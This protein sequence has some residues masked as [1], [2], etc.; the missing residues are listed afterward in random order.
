MSGAMLD[1]RKDKLTSREL[2]SSR[3]DVPQT[4]WP[5]IAHKERAARAL[6]KTGYSTIMRRY[7][8]RRGPQPFVQARPITRHYAALA[9]LN[10]GPSCSVQTRPRVGCHAAQGRT[11]KRGSSVGSV[12][13]QKRT[14]AAT[15]SKVVF[16]GG[17]R[18]PPKNCGGA[19][20][21]HKCWPTGGV[22]LGEVLNRKSARP[23][24]TQ[25]SAEKV[26]TPQR[27]R[28]ALRPP[29][30][31]RTVQRGGLT[32]SAALSPSARRPLKASSRVPGARSHVQ[33]PQT[34]I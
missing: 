11:D 24:Q 9:A 32:G 12:V 18:A 20:S 13:P 4:F 6:A 33:N 28:Q 31:P 10:S 15:D 29:P 14:T 21:G 22:G 5:V 34:Q 2:N 3:R 25:S 8:T 16:P 30:P 7:Q 1:T 19:H 27:G 23:G 26:K 17:L